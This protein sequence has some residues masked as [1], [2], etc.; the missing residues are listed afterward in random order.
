MTR[1]KSVTNFEH[2][3]HG[4]PDS[5][6][7]IIEEGH[8]SPPVVP[9]TPA[10]ASTPSTQ[11]CV[12]PATSQ[13][14]QVACQQQ[15]LPSPPMPGATR[16]ADYQN[17]GYTESVPSP[18]RL[19]G[20]L[21]RHGPTT[22][23]ALH[24]GAMRELE[25]RRWLSDASQMTDPALSSRASELGKKRDQ[26]ISFLRVHV[27]QIDSC[28]TKLLIICSLLQ[29]VIWRLGT[30]GEI[31]FCPSRPPRR[32]PSRKKCWRST[33]RI[34]AAT[35]GCAA[36]CRRCPRGSPTRIARRHAF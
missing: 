12:I 18:S 4:V 32:R 5:E 33:C 24:D 15:W 14:P 29:L 27:S 20:Y 2:L 21:S 3:R 30:R 36:P 10:L 25:L 26:F 6:Q 28:V 35:Q 23:T 8:D 17:Y 1:V 7:E 16:P 19:T 11:Q 9:L 34:S 31:P 13:Q 22:P